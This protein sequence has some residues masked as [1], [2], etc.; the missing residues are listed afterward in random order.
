M[1][2][3]K[4][5]TVH[6]GDGR[7]LDNCDIL[8]KEGRIAK[9]GEN[10]TAGETDA[11][12]IDATGR[13]VFPGFID[14]ASAIGAMGIPTSYPDINEKTNPVMPELN[15]KYSMDPDEVNNQEFYKS[16][17]TAIALAPGNANVIGGQMAVFKTAPAKMAKRLVKEK[18]GL[19]CAVTGD[20]IQAYG[21]RDIAPMTRMGIFQIFESSLREAEKQQEKD[22]TEA[23]KVLVNALEGRMPF[24]ISA[25]LA[26]EMNAVFHLF[27][28][29]GGS[30]NF[31]DGYGFGNCMDR[32]LE[33]KAGLVLGN[34]NNLSQVTKHGMDLSLL[35]RLVENGNL[36]A[37]TNS[38]DGSSEG[39]EVL[40]WT[41]I[42]VYRAGI[43]AEEVVK[44][45]SLN[46]ARMLGVDDRLGSI[47]PGKDAD[48][49][50]YTGHPVTTYAARVEHSIVDGEVIF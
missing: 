34:I 48:L 1:Y 37:F 20:V 43:G 10:L 6:V 29:R 17:I 42:E 40:L 33:K 4:H 12:S 8:I 36:I 5:G 3:V 39:R 47:E 38:C 16:G 41:A 15:I 18:A 46:P 23:Q 25:E 28:G 49:S 35:K 22:R 45:L 14:S 26:Q 2:I 24:F 21:R 30:I 19:K 27:E 50:I 13:H 32:L 44:M 9:V 7:V 11:V 31:I